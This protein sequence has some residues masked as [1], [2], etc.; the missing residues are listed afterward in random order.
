MSVQQGVVLIAAIGGIAVSLQAQFL[1]LI[2]RRLGT[3]ESVFLTYVTGGLLIALMLP[4]QRDHNLS[5]L[6]QLPWYAWTGGAL[7]LVI[8]G[9]IGYSAPRLGLVAAL[10]I[11]VGAQFITGALI[12][13]FGLFGADLRPLDLA[14]VAGLG[15]IVVG[16][17]LT[18]K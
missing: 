11:V 2:D 3:F 12:D 14:R 15:L 1:G 10:S 18:L 8:V 9:T 17:W 16:I 13:H 6:T 4:L 5:A 7:G